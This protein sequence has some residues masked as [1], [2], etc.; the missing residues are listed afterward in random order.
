MSGQLYFLDSWE[1]IAGLGLNLPNIE[2]NK[3]RATTY[4][5]VLSEVCILVRKQF[6]CGYINH[7]N[8]HSGKES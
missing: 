1:K 6:I 8:H 2:S 5:S 3:K 4:S 7:F